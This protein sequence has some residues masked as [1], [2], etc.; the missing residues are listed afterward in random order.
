MKQTSSITI[1]CLTSHTRAYTHNQQQH[2]VMVSILPRSASSACLLF[3]SVMSAIP[4]SYNGIKQPY[5]LT[6]EDEAVIYRQITV[7]CN[8]MQYLGHTFCLALNKCPI[9]Q[10]YIYICFCFESKTLPCS[11]HMEITT[12]EPSERALSRFLGAYCD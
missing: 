1:S 10:R 9:T 7:K 6:E 4:S 11:L 2:L 5:G 8:M 12:S 3:L